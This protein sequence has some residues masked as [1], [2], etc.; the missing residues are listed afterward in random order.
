MRNCMLIQAAGL[1]MLLGCASPP[2]DLPA[3]SELAPASLPSDNVGTVYHGWDEVGHGPVTTTVT[4]VAGDEVSFEMASGC[5]FARKDPILPVLSWDNCGSDPNWRSGKRLF[6]SSTG[7]LW[8]LRVG[9]HASYELSWTGNG[10]QTD[11]GT[12][13]CDV[14]GTAHI[15]VR[16]GEFDTYKV[17]CIQR[18]AGVTRNRT[19]YWSPEV[20]TV[21][22][23][24]V[25]SKKGLTDSWELVSVDDA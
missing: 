18:W 21:K 23:T 8:P 22:F 19:T 25:H 24:D 4:G 14:T 2:A 9:N 12:L 11:R 7:S 6:T 20:G 3:Q 1:L 5:E 15:V 10:G 16:A 17:V 13:D